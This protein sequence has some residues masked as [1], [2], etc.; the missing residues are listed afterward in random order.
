MKGQ[1]KGV[2]EEENK[3][4]ARHTNP[5][6]LFNKNSRAHINKQNK[7]KKGKRES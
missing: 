7:N 4:T 6:N 2:I 5:Q 3:K 1:V